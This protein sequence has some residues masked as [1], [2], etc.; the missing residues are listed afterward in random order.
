MR[1]KVAILGVGP[2]AAFVYQACKDAGLEPHEIAVFGQGRP[3]QVPVGTFWIHA[4]PHLDHEVTAHTILI[5]AEGTEAGYLRK[6]WGN[7]H[8]HYPS[9]FP[10]ETRTEIGYSPFEVIPLLWSGL[11]D[12][13]LVQVGMLDTADVDRIATFFDLVFQTFPTAVS[14]RVRHKSFVKIPILLY[15]NTYDATYHRVRYSGAE[16]QPWVRRCMLFGHTSFEF[17]AHLKDPGLHMDTTGGTVRWVNDLHPTVKPLHPAQ[18]SSDNIV[19]IGRFAEW[20]RK[21]LSH[22]AYSIAYSKIKS[23]ITP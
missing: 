10:H 1:K 23:V 19:L 5:T 3:E 16:E 4:I 7:G 8:D 12:E 21:R 18:V 15:P 2:T 22:Q 11:D 9:S 17:P 14:L 13:Q 20:N 6:Q